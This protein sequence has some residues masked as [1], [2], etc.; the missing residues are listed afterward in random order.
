MTAGANGLAAF[1]GELTYK[2]PLTDVRGRVKLSAQRSRMG[3]IYADRTRLDGGY[4]LGMRDGTF[5]MVGDFAA[6]SAALDPSML[7]GVTQPLAAAA[8]TPI[9][10][11]ATS[12]GN[13]ISRTARNFNS[14]GTIRVVNFPGGGAARITSADIIGPNGAR[15]RVFGGSGVTYYWPSGGLR[16]D[17]NIEMA[18]GGLPHGAGHAFASRAPERR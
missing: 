7:A 18:G 17:G 16:I 11:V 3:T 4:Q 2:G 1:A 10:P 12:I 9:G 15:A 5:A 8:K 13:A 6:D 14:A